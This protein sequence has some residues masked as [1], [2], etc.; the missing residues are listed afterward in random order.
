MECQWNIF[1]LPYFQPRPHH[2]SVENPLPPL[3]SC[4]RA[5]PAWVDG[6]RICGVHNTGEF[7]VRVNKKAAVASWTRGDAYLLLLL[8]SGCLCTAVPRSLTTSF[9]YLNQ[10]LSRE[11]FSA[12]PLATARN[13]YFAT[14]RL[15]DS[16]LCVCCCGCN[17]INIV[18]LSRESRTTLSRI[19]LQ[20]TFAYHQHHVPLT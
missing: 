12:F 3:T 11:A 14:P 18:Y 19:E 1:D 16:N 6:K 15:H 2:G 17:L 13:A 10:H 5:G 9:G 7:R 20:I 4:R 8:Y